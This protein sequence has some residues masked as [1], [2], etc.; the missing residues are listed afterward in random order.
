MH[1]PI[2]IAK[3]YSKAST[4]RLQAMHDALRRLDA[5]GISGDVVECGVWRGGHIILARMV[6]P[7]RH[8]WLYD[9][10]DGMTKPGPHDVK[11]KATGR[12]DA[13][14]LA[15][16][17]TPG[18]VAPLDDVKN[19]FSIEGVLDHS[20][21]T[22]VQGDVCQT[23]LVPE[24]MPDKIALLRLDTDWFESTKIELEVLWPRL[25]KGGVIIVDDYGHWLGARKAVQEYFAVHVP[26]F[27]K[28][29]AMIDYTAAAMVK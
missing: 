4:Q 6:S 27:G 28:R 17:K 10:F 24:N 15:Q 11:A 22:F 2:E 12:D 14:M 5:A 29:L 20:K 23:L 3:R 1:T 16:K 19:Y 25:V 13:E 8:C 18:T 21:L 26:D 9:T 7:Q